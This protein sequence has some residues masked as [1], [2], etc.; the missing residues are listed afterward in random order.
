MTENEVLAWLR[1][2]RVPGIGPA[3]GR[4]LIEHFGDV[5]TIFEQSFK[6]L[7]KLPGVGSARAEKLLNPGFLEEAKE[8]F[9]KSRQQDIQCLPMAD[10][11]YPEL[12]RECPDR[13]R[14][15]AFL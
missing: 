7:V 11:A 2:Q 6:E 4:K 8:E 14:V 9:L 5:Q 12:L 3:N 13:K 1:L 10:R 15:A